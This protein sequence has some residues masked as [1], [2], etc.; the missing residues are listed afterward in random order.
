M[1]RHSGE[2][3]SIGKLI[4]WSGWITNF[5]Q[6]LGKLVTE[7]VPISYHPVFTSFHECQTSWR[8]QQDQLAFRA[9]L[10]EVMSGGFQK[11]Y[12]HWWKSRI[13]GSQ[14]WQALRFLIWLILQTWRWREHVPPKRWLTFNGLHG[15]T[16]QKTELFIGG[17]S[18]QMHL[19]A[20]YCYWIWD[21]APAPHM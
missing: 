20:P 8:K 16:Y 3:I 1:T 15:V 21:I 13:W 18:R 5:C 7:M 9:V 6:Q 4:M 19:R 17:R 14:R 11:L 2:W 12:K 10:L